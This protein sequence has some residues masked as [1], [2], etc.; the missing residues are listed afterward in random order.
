MRLQF[1]AKYLS[2][3]PRSHFH[4]TTA[5]LYLVLLFSVTWT[6]YICLHVVWTR[7]TTPSPHYLSKLINGCRSLRQCSAVSPQCSIMIPIS[8]AIVHWRLFWRE[9][10]V[11]GVDTLKMEIIHGCLRPFVGVASEFMKFILTRPRLSSL[12]YEGFEFGTRMWESG[13][14]GVDRY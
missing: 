14:R 4:L 7:V 1:V 13:A 3:Q 5:L 9:R 2:L 12:C 10:R 8:S 11:N 6:R